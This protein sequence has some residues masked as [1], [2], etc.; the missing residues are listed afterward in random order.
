MLDLDDEPVFH[1]NRA[2]WSEAWS[3]MRLD[4]GLRPEVERLY[5]AWV[6][7]L[8]SSSRKSGGRI[9][10]GIGRAP[11]DWRRGWARSSTGSSPSC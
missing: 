1:E 9:R 6:G 4:D 10:P 11:G 2:L 7:R 3:L 8:T 5:R